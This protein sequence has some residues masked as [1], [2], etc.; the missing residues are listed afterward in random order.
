MEVVGLIGVRLM[1]ELFE[2]EEFELDPDGGII[3]VDLLKLGGAMTVEE[4]GVITV[5]P[6][7]G[8]TP[9]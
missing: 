1:T 2:I 9:A 7:L 5:D 8:N 4:A 3:R 6:P